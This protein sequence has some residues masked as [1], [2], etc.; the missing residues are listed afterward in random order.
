M[1]WKFD[2]GETIKTLEKGITNIRSQSNPSAEQ[3]Q[4]GRLM[5]VMLMD[6]VDDNED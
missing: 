6:L 5:K 4:R 1:V 2:K 3:V